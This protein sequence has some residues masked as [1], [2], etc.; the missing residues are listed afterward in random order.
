MSPS[1][2][3]E[4]CASASSATSARCLVGHYANACGGCQECLSPATPPSIVIPIT[5]AHATSATDVVE[6]AVAIPPI[7]PEDIVNPI[8]TIRSATI[9]ATITRVVTVN[10]LPALAI[11]AGHSATT[12]LAQAVGRGKSYQKTYYHYS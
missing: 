10:K 9:P 12:S 1:Q 4:T 3:S 11:G 7:A 5:I 6:V 8:T 2:A